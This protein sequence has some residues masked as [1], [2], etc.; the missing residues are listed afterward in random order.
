MATSEEDEWLESED[1]NEEEIDQV[2]QSTIYK[3]NGAEV[4]A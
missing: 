3:S 1:V 4:S 2:I